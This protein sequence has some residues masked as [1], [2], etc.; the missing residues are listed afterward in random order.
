MG[1]VKVNDP[2][3]VDRAA[4]IRPGRTK[5]SELGQIL[6]AD[7]S[8]RMPIQDGTI[9]GYTY[10]D[11]KAN[12]LILI[13][14]N[15]TKSQTVAQTLYVMIDPETG[16][17]KKVFIP[18]RKEIVAKLGLPPT[19]KDVGIG[20]AKNSMRWVSVDTFEKKFE[21]GYILTPTFSDSIGF[22]SHDLLI[23]FDDAGTVT[24]VSRT[25]GDGE[26]VELIEWREVKR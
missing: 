25:K 10:A 26:K 20:I 1:R 2:S 13:L 7:P 8:L 24:L 11:T 14:F 12:G 9:L 4:Y 18:E 16:V 21:A 3:I 17:V 23:T 15:F 19:V 5:V 6:H 22:Y